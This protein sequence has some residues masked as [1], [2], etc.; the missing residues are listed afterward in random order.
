[1]LEC[2]HKIRQQE[3]GEYLQYHIPHQTHTSCLLPNMAV[4]AQSNTYQLKK[5]SV[6]YV[7]FSVRLHADTMF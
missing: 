6:I 2:L 5:F 3:L 1:M 7:T 4:K